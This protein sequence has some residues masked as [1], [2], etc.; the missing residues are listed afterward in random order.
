MI[1]QDFGFTRG[2]ALF[3]NPSRSAL[4]LDPALAPLPGR[5]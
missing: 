2:M 1:A 3:E 5:G 4:D